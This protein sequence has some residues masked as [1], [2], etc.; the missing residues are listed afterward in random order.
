MP[1]SSLAFLRNSTDSE[2]TQETESSSSRERVGLVTR[3]PSLS[4][5]YEVEWTTEAHAPHVHDG[6]PSFNTEINFSPTDAK[7][8]DRQIIEKWRK[9]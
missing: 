7:P 6:S 8:P 9:R 1:K 5:N 3:D 4:G 2:R